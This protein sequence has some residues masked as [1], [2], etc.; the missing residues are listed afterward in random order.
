M[1]TLPT[2]YAHVWDTMGANLDIM[3]T[4]MGMAKAMVMDMEEDMDM[5]E[6]MAMDEDM[7]MEGKSMVME[8]GAMVMEDTEAKILQ[9]MLKNN[10]FTFI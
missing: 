4:D 3:A 7:V 2:S 1:G 8:T 9:K 5:A 10:N 6:D